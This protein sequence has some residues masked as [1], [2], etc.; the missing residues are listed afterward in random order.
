MNRPYGAVD[1]AANLKGAVPKATTQK[2]LVSL[3][4][5]GELVQKVYGKT[6][7]FVYSQA[8]IE[9][10]P[11]EKIS[12]L[13]TELAKNEEEN[14]ALAAEVK[15]LTAE[16]ARIKATPTD[17]E[18]DSHIADVRASIAKTTE[19]LEP[20]RSGAPPITAEELDRIHADWSKWRAEWIRRRKVFITFWQLA[21]DALPP[22][23]AKNLEEDLGI[24]NDSPEHTA[25][26]R[27][28]LCQNPK[29][30]PLKR[31]RP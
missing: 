6:T 26:E 28:A 31:K 7:F 24:E 14:Q 22:Q 4:E 19:T 10:L 21:T 9:C 12:E 1:V 16:L 23:D 27:G 3:A 20:L 2:I 13:K 15:S 18:L 17:L 11:N 30:N 29:T 25:I 8:K 5:K